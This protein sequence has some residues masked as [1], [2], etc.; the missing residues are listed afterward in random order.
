MRA[1]RL[2]GASNWRFGP[3]RS[4]KQ[5]G[6]AKRGSHSARAGASAS[7]PFDP[8][9]LL[10]PPAAAALLGGVAYAHNAQFSLSPS[11]ATALQQY[12]GQHTPAH[13]WE[14]VIASEPGTL[15]VLTAEA[16]LAQDHPF[17]EDDHMFSAF[18]S[19]GIVEDLTGYYNPEQRR[20][21]SVVALGREVCGFPR[22]VHG[23]LTAAM[24]DESFGGLLFSLKQAKA[25]DFWG[26]AYTVALEVQYKAKIPA[27]Q[28]LL[29]TAE[30]ES[31]EGRKVWMKATMTDGPGGKVFATSRALFVAP[32]LQKVVPMVT[33]YLWHRVFGSKKAA[34]ANLE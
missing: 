17:L 14:E 30:V 1:W 32:K 20:W 7:L 19:K 9:W 31:A 23:G 25:L 29:C 8:K 28:R 5:G 21:H 33:S 15:R 12:S 11:V 18:V 2:T 34:P 24:F 3:R 13:D 6:D 26:P 4:H 16:L 27:G 10:L 22:V